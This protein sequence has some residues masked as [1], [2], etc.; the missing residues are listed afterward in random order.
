[1]NNN[2]SQKKH[3][4]FRRVSTAGQD[5]LTQEAADL[6]YREKLPDDE[7]LIINEIATSAN[8]KA[9]N[10]RP[11]MQR[12]IS[13]VKDKKVHTIYAFDRSRLFRDFYEGMEFN[14]LRTKYNVQVI[15]TSVGNGNMPASDDVFVEGL[16][17]MFSDIE[18]KNIARRSR[19]ARLRYPA[20]KFGYLKQKETKRFLPDSSKREGVEQYFVAL[21]GVGSLDDLYKVMKVYR[22]KF[23]KTD[24]QLISM[25]RDPFYAG[26][27]LDKGTN[28]LHHVT[29]Y[30]SIEEFIQLQRSSGEIFKAFLERKKSLKGQNMYS[31]YCGY[32]QKLL[33]YKIEEESNRAYYSCST[34][35]HPKVTVPITD[36]S[37]I[38]RCTLS[39]ITQNFDAEKLIHH[40]LNCYRAIKKHLEAEMNS[41]DQNLNGILEEIVLGSDD[42]SADWKDDPIY[43]RKQLLKQEYQNCLEQI[44][45]NQH[46]LQ[47]N[48]SVIKAIQGALVNQSN[49]TSMLCDMLI[50]GI[51]VY[52]SNIQVDVFFFDY[53]QEMEKEIIFEGEDTA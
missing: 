3:V 25:A 30:I 41:I 16:L 35:L 11:E 33:I 20:K 38:I 10:E 14:D 45:E 1:M 13:L 47:K 40:S 21:K 42:Y 15:Y 37:K 36:L 29:P 49:N 53:L 27:D 50:N 24:E 52:E 46:A 6:P 26:Y 43:K 17:S 51:W 28:K 22:K 23:K 19:E 48:K 32:C 9:I 44:K 31:P 18:G 39:E 5:I 2:N 34:K 4:F 8:K 7:I 12:L